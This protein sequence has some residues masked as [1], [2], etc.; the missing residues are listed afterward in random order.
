MHGRGLE[1]KIRTLS[2]SAWRLGLG[3]LLHVLDRYCTLEI[4]RRENRGLSAYL[5]RKHGLSSHAQN[6]RPPDR[7]LSGWRREYPV[8][9]ARTLQQVDHLYII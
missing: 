2:I 3:L 6:E 9:G 4:V 8:A 5:F 1:A 7:D